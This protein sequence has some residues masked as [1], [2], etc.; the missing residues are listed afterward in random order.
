MQK[1]DSE[2]RVAYLGQED[3]LGVGN[4][5]EV[6]LILEKVETVAK[7]EFVQSGAR[8]LHEEDANPD[9]EW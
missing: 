4:R 7:Y 2:G 6:E 8:L 9:T 3:T 5:D 1:M